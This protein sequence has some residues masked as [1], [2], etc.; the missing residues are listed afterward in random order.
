MTT[1]APLNVI[2]TENLSQNIDFTVRNV[3]NYNVI[4]YKKEKLNNNNVKTLG[5]LRSVITD[6]TNILCMAPPKSVYFDQFV[7]E[8]NIEDCYFE[9]FIEGT[10]INVFWDHTIGDW[11]ISTKSNI[12]AKCKYNVTSNKTFRYM[13]LDAMNHC[14]LEFGFLDPGVMYSFVLQHPENRIVIPII[15]PKIYLAAAYKI[16]KHPDGIQKVDKLS[17]IILPGVELVKR[18]SYEQIQTTFG[19]SWQRLKNYFNDDDLD[20]KT[21]GFVVY[22]KDGDR[23]KIRSKNYE[24]VKMLKGNTPKI[25]FHYYCLRKNGLVRDFLQFYP[26]YKDEFRQL[27]RDMHTFT[28]K[29]YQ[30][31]IQCYI[32]KEKKVKDYPY[33]F[34]IHMFNLHRIYIEDLM[35]YKKFVSKQVVID[36]VNNLHP[37]KLMYSI[38]YVY[39]KH[40]LEE[41]TA[42]TL[43]A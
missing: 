3:G 36:Y 16:Y 19:D 34:K 7:N 22:N 32:K 2:D 38:N 14:G 27:R 26:E 13:F 41:K 20:Y 4:K 35:P 10:M 28:D 39:N 40:K 8:N 17:N 43:S 11:N 24:K 37:A 42:E 12:G 6:G 29:L 9:E 30:N 23:M 21:H 18:Y 15:S 5:Q 1:Y 31:Y 25:Q 33:N